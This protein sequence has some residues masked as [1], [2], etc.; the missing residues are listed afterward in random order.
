MY[1]RPVEIDADAS[2]PVK[3]R[4]WLA[5]MIEID[6]FGHQAFPPRTQLNASNVELISTNHI[7]QR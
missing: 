5:R 3:T 6:D 2:S 7:D 4:C 1:Y